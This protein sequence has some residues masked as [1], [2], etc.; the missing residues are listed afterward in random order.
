MQTFR[1]L[2]LATALAAIVYPAQAGEITGSGKEITI[3]GR[4]ECAFSGQNDLDGDP[5][6]PGFKTQSYGQNVRL[7]PLDPSTLDPNADAPF[8]PI[9]G[10]ACNPNRGRDLN[11][12]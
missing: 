9:P 10:F 3:N 11:D 8:V 5:R 2:A 4:S 1:K 6:D 7:T 12:E